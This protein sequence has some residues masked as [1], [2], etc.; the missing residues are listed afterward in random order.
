MRPQVS[1]TWIKVLHHHT[2]L[3]LNHVY[4]FMTCREKYNFVFEF[5]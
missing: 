2:T 1:M 4:F 3:F 5:C